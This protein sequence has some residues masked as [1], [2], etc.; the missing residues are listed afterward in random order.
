MGVSLKQ[1]GKIRGIQAAK[2]AQLDSW[3]RPGKESGMPGQP[4]DRASL[5]DRRRGTQRNKNNGG[6]RGSDGR[7]RVQHDTERAVVSVRGLGV[8]VRHLHYGQESQ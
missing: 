8:N 7:G 5:D 6:N 2:G 1:Y 4:S 3:R